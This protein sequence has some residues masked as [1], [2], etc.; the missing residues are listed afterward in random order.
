M[1]NI[2]IDHEI[3]QTK[4]QTFKDP[5]TTIIKIDLKIIHK[6]GIQTITIDKKLLSIT[7]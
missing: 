4:D 2:I 5:I 7:S 1:I 3:I 6:I